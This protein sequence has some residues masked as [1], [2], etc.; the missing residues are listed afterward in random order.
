M[1][2]SV[3]WTPS[4]PLSSSAFNQMVEN[5]KENYLSL[6]AAA[7]PTIAL[8]VMSRRFE[9]MPGNVPTRIPAL[10]L[11]AFRIPYTGW[12][13]AHFSCPAAR[14]ETTNSNPANTTT[15]FLILDG[16]HFVVTCRHSRRA[17]AN[18]TY[19]QTTGASLFNVQEGADAGN[20]GKI[21]ARTCFVRS[22][23][24]VPSAADG[25]I[26]LNKGD[27]VEWHVYTYVANNNYDAMTADLRQY[28]RIIVNDIQP[29]DTRMGFGSPR[30]YNSGNAPVSPPPPLTSSPSSDAVVPNKVITNLSTNSSN[31]AR[32]TFLMI[33]F[34][35][36][37]GLPD[38]R[39]SVNI[40]KE[41]NYDKTPDILASGYE[42]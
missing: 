35:G 36:T 29:S 33:Q 22:G 3:Q 6:N 23:I 1:Y 18:T 41:L 12:Y 19:D 32:K 11:D 14:Q 9:T 39:Y 38:S 4:T 25:Y 27:I 37:G 13:K 7:G 10:S 42:V 8:A 30:T 24:S 40:E 34:I 31:A 26:W 20:I 21:V 16:Y 15:G 28:G 5:D 2:K 17:S